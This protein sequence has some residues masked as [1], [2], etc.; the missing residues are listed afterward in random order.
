MSQ[1]PLKSAM[2]P[3]ADHPLMSVAL[4]NQ[5]ISYTSRHAILY[6]LGVGF[7]GDPKSGKE[8]A[9][10]WE[11]PLLKTL[12]TLATM[13]PALDFL[14]DS[15]WDGHQALHIGQ[16]LE[17]YRPLP[18]AGNLLANQRVVAVYDGA[19]AQGTCIVVQSDIRLANDDSAV[20]KLVS[21]LVAPADGAYNQPLAARSISHRLPARS[22]DLSC[23]IAT[24]FD[25]ALLFRLS[26]DNNPLHADM[27]A[28]QAAGFNGPLLHGRCLLGIA[29]R[30]ILRTICDYD[31]TLITG[32]EAAFVAPAYPGEVLTTDMW[33]ERNI[34]SFR[35]SVKE[36]KTIVVDY[37]K[38][39]LAA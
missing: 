16:R 1:F 20:F 24:R 19:A 25:Q 14:Q 4:E 18:A 17:M 8:L 32:I 10:V 35:C 27:H 34:V 29:G 3:D 37:G 36:R 9:Y 28:A 33:Q 22:P 31:Y 12:P 39:T 7:G 11:R 2:R 26:G 5:P 15:D 23:S 6:A 21:T 38:C 13:L 30:A